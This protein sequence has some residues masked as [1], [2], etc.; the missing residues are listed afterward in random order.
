MMIV[1]M[2]MVIVMVAVVFTVV[3]I[4]IIVVLIRAH[5]RAHRIYSALRLFYFLY[6]FVVLLVN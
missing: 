6:S 1:V 4:T 5:D 2:M 3:A